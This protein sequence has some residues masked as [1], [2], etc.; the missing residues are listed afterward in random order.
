MELTK[1]EGGDKKFITVLAD[2]KFHQTVPEGTE[3]AV[4]REY[5]DKDDV[6]KTKTELVFDEVSGVITKI[7]FKDGD[8]GKMLELEI[9][10]EGIVSIGTAS[11][12]GED[13]MKKLPNV[14]LSEVVKLVPYSFETDKGKTKKG[15]TVYQNDKKIESFYWDNETKKAINGIPEAEAGLDYK[16]EDGKIFFMTVRKFLVEEVKKLTINF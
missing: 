1:R 16:S 4:V 8:Y 5:E 9:D 12:F 13:L 6:K 10:N 15:I 11:N 3:G 2:G 14:K 7:A